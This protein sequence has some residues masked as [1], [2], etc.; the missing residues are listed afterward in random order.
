MSAAIRHP[1]RLLLGVLV[2]VLAAGVATGSAAS[3]AP[4]AAAAKCTGTPV[5]Y[6][7]I[8]AISPNQTLGAGQPYAA[9]PQEAAAKAV[10]ATCELGVP[11][12][13]SVCDSKGDLNEAADCARKGVE[14]GW[15]AWAGDSITGAQTY[16]ILSAAGIPELGGV[17]LAPVELLGELWFPYEGNLAGILFLSSIAA[18]ANTPDPAALAIPALDNPGVSLIN[19]IFETQMKAVNGT[20]AAKIA[21]PATATDMSQYA[22]QVISSE[23]NSMVP[24]LTADQYSG[25]LQQLIQQGTK[26]T[27]LAV[28]QRSNQTSDETKE[29][30]GADL[31]GIWN[32]HYTEITNK[33]NPGVKQYFKELKAVKAP[34]SETALNSDVAFENWV[35]VHNVVEL[36]K[37]SPTKD[38]ATFV[39][40][41]TT[42][43]PITQPGFPTVNFG[44]NPYA[45]DPSLANFTIFNNQFAVTR[46]NAKLK[47]VPVTK[48]F[49]TVG[50]EFTPKKL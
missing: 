50:D 48:G 22:A 43:G 1:R 8:A 44:V 34:T 27:D 31:K 29:Q 17:G 35:W 4:P 6:G 46:F 38:A 45:S 3:A 47:E 21:V 2:V 14:E 40:Q 13:I 24:V 28:V 7:V 41:L 15:V 32:S 12:K 37:D 20:V 23:A 11:L 18:N 16:P 33:A 26:F 39:Q 36:L 30:L 9:S 19:T 5:V 25:M 49:I 10:N 42:V